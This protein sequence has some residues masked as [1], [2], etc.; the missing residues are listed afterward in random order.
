MEAGLRNQSWQA[1]RYRERSS[2]LRALAEISRDE[3]EREAM[4]IAADEY[5][6]LASI[7]ENGQRHD[8]FGLRPLESV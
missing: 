3:I 8:D 4:A 7:L 5:Q 6:R 1:L 2:E